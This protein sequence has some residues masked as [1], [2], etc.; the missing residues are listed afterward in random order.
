[1]SGYDEYK[2]EEC[3][4]NKQMYAE[5]TENIP[6]GEDIF[7]SALSIILI[8]LL[9]FYSNIYKLELTLPNFNN[10]VISINYMKK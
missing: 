9:W 5:I 10:I 2:K 7:I 1:M 6:K 8:K 4:K 3:K